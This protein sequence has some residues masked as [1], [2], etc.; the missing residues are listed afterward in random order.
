V[1][2]ELRPA[3]PLADGVPL[4]YY[5]AANRTL[6]RPVKAGMPIVMGDVTLDGESM[7]AT[8]RAHQDRAFFGAGP[9]VSAQ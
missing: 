6:L 7:L 1:G 2:A 5:L 9:G 3:A 8:L 4:P